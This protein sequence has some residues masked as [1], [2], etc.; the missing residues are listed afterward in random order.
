ML[1]ALPAGVSV[2]NDPSMLPQVNVP[3][4]VR[5]EADDPLPTVIS[6]STAL[7]N[8]HIESPN[9]MPVSLG[10]EPL[11]V[12][13]LSPDPVPVSIVSTNVHLVPTLV[14][15]NGGSS[16]ADPG[17]EID[18]SKYNTALTSLVGVDRQYET[19]AWLGGK[20]TLVATQENS[21]VRRLN[22]S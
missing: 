10:P 22:L 8:V 11:D 9:P 19:P 1:P 7:V 21:G 15:G 4:V 6:G 5:V 12:N 17:D 20:L 2:P 18:T 13:L 16:V 14:S 3:G